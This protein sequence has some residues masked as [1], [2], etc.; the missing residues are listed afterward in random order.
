VLTRLQGGA[1]AVVV[2][3]VVALLLALDDTDRGFRGWWEARALTTDVVAGVLV[4]LLTLLVV[5]GL[6][7]RRQTH[8]RSRAT[9]AQAAILVAQASRTQSEVVR[10]L[11]GSDARESA[12]EEFRTYMMMLLIAAPL[13]IEGS[14]S[15]QVLEAAQRLGGE[16]A[17]ALGALHDTHDPAA[18]RIRV[19]EAGTKLRTAATP[20]LQPLEIA[21]LVTTD[22]GNQV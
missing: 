17:R 9:G 5:D 4:L 21:S 13:L 20:L 15:R 18:S 16:L 3:V 11:D 19:T 14:V 7:R 6:L 1:A 12:G 22:L 8:Q 2:T 10:L